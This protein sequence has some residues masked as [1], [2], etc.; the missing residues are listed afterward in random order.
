MERHASSLKSLGLGNMRL[1]KGNWETTF[2]K[3]HKCL[4]LQ[5]L[6]IC[7]EPFVDGNGEIVA[8]S[9]HLRW[10]HV[11][12]LGSKQPLW[13]RIEDWFLEEGVDPFLALEPVVSH[14]TDCAMVVCQDHACTC[15]QYR[16]DPW[17][18]TGHNHPA[19]D[20][21]GKT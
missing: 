8:M 3:M 12:I 6:R 15:D 13:K 17:Y 9:A 1:R 14:F 7:G 18:M 16:D 10:R 11:Q 5:D 4:S 19:Y 20:M 2:R 21:D